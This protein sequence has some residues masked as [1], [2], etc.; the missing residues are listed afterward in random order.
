MLFFVVFLRPSRKAIIQYILD[1]KLCGFDYR[2]PAFNCPDGG[3]KWKAVP[4]EKPEWNCELSGKRSWFW[5]CI[6]YI[7]FHLIYFCF[8]K[9]YDRE[10]PWQKTSQFKYGQ[11]W[12]QGEAVKTKTIFC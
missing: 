9:D 1:S 7:K 12:D 5:H 2:S 8:N 11:R 10:N 4:F 6:K 3:N